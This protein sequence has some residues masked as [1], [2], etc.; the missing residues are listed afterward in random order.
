MIV[1]NLIKLKMKKNED[2]TETR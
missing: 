2:N 1:A